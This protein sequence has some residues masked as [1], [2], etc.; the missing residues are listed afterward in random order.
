VGVGAINFMY[1]SF[2]VNEENQKKKFFYLE[3]N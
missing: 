2:S 3:R 1:S